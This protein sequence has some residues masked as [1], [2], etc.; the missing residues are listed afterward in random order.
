MVNG[1]CKCENRIS[2][3]SLV[4]QRQGGGRSQVSRR[5]EEHSA[6]STPPPGCLPV[7]SEGLPGG[8]GSPVNLCLG[9]AMSP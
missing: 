2:E 3:W 5:Q 1:F 9:L 6:E 4:S 8:Q 7:A